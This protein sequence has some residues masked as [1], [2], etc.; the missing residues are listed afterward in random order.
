MASYSKIVLI[1]NV[2][3]DPTLKVI[4][5]N[6][7]VAEF[8]LA[9]NETQVSNGQ[10]F[11]KTE[12]YRISVWNQRADTIVNYVKKGNSIYVEGKLTVRTYTDKEGKERYSLEVLASDFTFLGSKSDGQAPQ[13]TQN[14]SYATPAQPAPVVSRDP[15]PEFVA[16][17][18]VDDDLPF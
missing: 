17:P 16:P 2:G 1:G 18:T 7:K 9:V 5:A 6:R 11:E 15:A 3:N 8:S 10:R 14:Q 4:D 13:G 12:W